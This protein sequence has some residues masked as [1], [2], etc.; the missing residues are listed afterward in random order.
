ML[1]RDKILM[2]CHK[3]MMKMIKGFMG[4]TSGY[5]LINEID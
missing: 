1:N 3:G 5:T 2:Q 4:F